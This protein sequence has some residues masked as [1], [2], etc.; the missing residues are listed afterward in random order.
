MKAGTDF[1]AEAAWLRDA[2][3]GR[4]AP[5][6]PAREP[7]LERVAAHNRLLPWLDLQGW[8]PPG[9]PAAQ[10][11]TR[12]ADGLRAERLLRAGTALAADLGAAG[13]PCLA[14]RGPFLA[15]TLYHDPAARP[16]QDIDLLVP[17]AQARPALAVAEARGYRLTGDAPSP[18][19][20]LRHHLH[21]Q[22][23]QPREGV[24]C[25]LHWAVDHPYRL[26]R[27]DYPALFA[28]ARSARHAEVTWSEP[29]REHGLLLDLLHLHKHLGPCLT[30]PAEWPRLC[31]RGEGLHLLDVARRLT[32][33]P[34]D[35]AAVVGLARDWRVEA[36]T[37]PPLALAARVFELPLPTDLLDS[38]VRLAASPMHPPRVPDWWRRW[39]AQRG[40][41]PEKWSDAAA[42]LWPPPRKLG[43][44]PRAHR[45]LRAPWAALRLACAG[46][47]FALAHWRL[48]RPHSAAA[49]HPS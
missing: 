9:S 6:W 24:L 4:A 22:L 32:V 17:R 30:T 44:C 41:R 11:S 27:V 28:A 15:A 14:L 16:A 46:A 49:P 38:A 3:T 26:H 36:E 40:F 18:S 7:R 35:L 21:W 43:R 23:H 29:S 20:A 25:D 31:A 42:Y 47:D 48:H 13:I 10:R 8:T 45:F 19:F 1:A 39:A 2:L 12:R 34:P 5:G 37:L 33:D